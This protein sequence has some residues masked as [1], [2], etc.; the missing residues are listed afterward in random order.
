VRLDPARPF[1]EFLS[2]VS[3]KTRKN[4]RNYQNRLARLGRLEHRVLTGLEAGPAIIE[5]FEGR[6]AWLST[7]GMTSEAFRD[8][9]FEEVMRSM[10]RT[11]P[12][13]LGLLAFVLTLDGRA[14]AVQWGFLRSGRYYAFMSSRDPAYEDYSAGRLHLQHVLEACH[15]LGVTEVDLMVPAIPYKMTWTDTADPLVDLV[16]TWTLRGRLVVDLYQGGVRPMLKR[17]AARLPAAVR[18]PLFELVNARRR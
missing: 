7:H 6:R 16:M 8:P 3:A 4:L 11:C 15:R 12:S 10:A 9:H 14:I 13:E 17:L 5:A 1:A 2:G 18:R